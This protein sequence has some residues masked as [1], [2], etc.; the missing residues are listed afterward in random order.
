[1]HLLIIY[2]WTILLLILT[3]WGVLC[4]SWWWGHWRRG[5][6]KLNN[7]RRNHPRKDQRPAILGPSGAEEH[8]PRRQSLGDLQLL[9]RARGLGQVCPRHEDHHRR[10]ELQG[11]LKVPLRAGFGPSSHRLG[12]EFSRQL[13]AETRHHCPLV[14]AVL[15]RH[16]GDDMALPWRLPSW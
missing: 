12:G 1:M 5:G 15:H 8:E 6:P 7:Q 13:E 4:D 16:S 3:D 2:S 9:Q 11:L 14:G 10:G